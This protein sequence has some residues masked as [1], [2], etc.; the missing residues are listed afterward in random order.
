MVLAYARCNYADPA[1]DVLREIR[2]GV[3]R[4]WWLNPEHPRHWD[5]GDSMA[6][7]YGAVVPM[8]ECRNLVQLGDF[9]RDLA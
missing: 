3:R 1:V 8:V 7:R 6:S 2:G 9:V 5:T 4:A